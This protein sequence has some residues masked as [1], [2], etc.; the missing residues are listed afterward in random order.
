VNHDKSQKKTNSNIGSISTPMKGFSFH[1]KTSSKK[2]ETLSIYHQD[3]KAYT[4]Q[5]SSFNAEEISAR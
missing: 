1:H 4:H 2:S 3:S 5:I